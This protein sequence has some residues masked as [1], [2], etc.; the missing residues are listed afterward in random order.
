MRAL[1]SGAASSLSGSPPASAENLAGDGLGELVV[2]EVAG[3]GEDHV[4]AVEAVAVVVEEL[5]LV[6]AGH[7]L[8][9]AEDGPAQRMVLPEALREELVDEDVGIVFVDL[10]LFKDHAALALDVGRG[11]DGIQH[12]VGEHVEGDG[13]MVGER[14][15]VEADGFLAGEGVEVAADGVHFAG[16]VLRGAGAGALEEHVLDKVGDAV[17]LGGLAAGAGL[18]PDAHGDGAQVIHALGQ[19]DQAVRQYGAAKVSLSCSS[20]SSQIRL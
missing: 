9:G 3:R 10:D 19:H 13:H 16:D 5:V 4:A 20:S 11:E 8:R 7:G 2:V 18:D 17:G 12:Q 14:L 15:D 6:E 1:A